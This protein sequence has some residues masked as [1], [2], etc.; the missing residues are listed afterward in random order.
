MTVMI[1]RFFGLPQELVRRG[2]WKQMKPGEHGLYIYLMEQSERLCSRLIRATD[3]EINEAVGVAPRTLCNARKKL[4]E[5]GI[6]LYEAKRGNRYA[7]TICNLQT[8]LPYPGDPKKRIEYVKALRRAPYIADVPP[9]GRAPE[10]ANRGPDPGDGHC[11]HGVPLAF[12][13]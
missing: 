9:T 3:S 8:G 10:S 5:R 1:E 11:P 2:I 7:Y 4:K 13:E 6:V 12:S